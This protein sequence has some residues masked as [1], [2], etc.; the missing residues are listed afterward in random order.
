L[1]VSQSSFNTFVLMIAS[2]GQF[3][4]IWQSLV[5]RALF[6][7]TNRIH[8]LCQ[9]GRALSYPFHLQAGHFA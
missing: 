9:G 6:F 3:L 5:A 7:Q 8:P 4:P 1:L 2:S